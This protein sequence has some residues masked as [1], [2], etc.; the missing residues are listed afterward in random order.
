MGSE[1]TAAAAHQVGVLRR[2]PMAMI[3]FCGYNMG[4]YFGHWLRV[5]KKLKHPPRIYSVNWFRTDDA[6]G[7]IWPGYGD[8]IRVMK[9]IIDRI[10]G[11]VGAKETPIGLMPYLKDLEVQGLNIPQGNLERLFEVKPSDWKAELDDIQKFL[12][13]F[14][15]HTPAEIR[16]E[17]RSLCEKLNYKPVLAG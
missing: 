13:Q 8:N 16:Q 14:G 9:W 4:D 12:D 15:E 11:R 17:H 6:G 3:P 10:Y 1:T 7:F 2:D 5:G